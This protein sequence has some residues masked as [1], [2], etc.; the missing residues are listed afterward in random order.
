MAG[1]LELN[2]SL[3][4]KVNESYYSLNYLYS[5][6][7]NHKIWRNPLL[8]ACS[9]GELS[10]DDFKFIF[11]QYYLYSKNFTKLLAIGMLRCD[12]D[13][14]RSELSKNIWEEGGGQDVELRHSEIFRKFLTKG[15]GIDLESIKFES[16]SKYFLNQY[17][18]IC[19]DS[20]PDECAAI[21]AFSTEGI[22]SRLYQILKHGLL[23]AKVSDYDLEFFNIHI[24]CDDDH[25]K[26]LADITL[27]YCDQA[28]WI[29]RCE[30]AINGALDL[31]DEFFNQIYNSLLSKKI[32]SLVRDISVPQSMID[33]VKNKSFNR[34]IKINSVNNILY[35]NKDT[36][37]GID[38][39][40]NRIALDTEVLDPRL[41]QISPGK[42]NELHKH[43]HET[44][45]F[46]LQGSGEVIIGDGVVDVTEGDVVYVPRWL[47]H[48]TKNTGQGILKFFAVTDYGLTKRFPKNSETCYRLKKP[49]ER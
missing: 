20:R 29:E 48:Q 9:N 8:L 43:A 35:K 6:K 46:I 33:I 44:I 1:I 26:T 3:N 17:I 23:N 49:I 36:N 11:S 2:F 22:V 27:S 45:F 12:S 30:L 42:H 38:F 10:I 16:Y 40:V 37:N 7:D 15:L 32:D 13:Y 25:A 28:H 19:L 31:R 5:V 14:H 21:L 34:T 18:D 39:I 41:V 24:A 47:P 4:N